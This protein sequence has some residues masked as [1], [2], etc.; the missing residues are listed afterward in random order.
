MI[1]SGRSIRILLLRARVFK[2]AQ[3]EDG[4]VVRESDMPQPANEVLRG[5]H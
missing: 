2:L 4:L 5:N 1:L 3:T